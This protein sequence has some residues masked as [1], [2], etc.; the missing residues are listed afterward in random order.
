MSKKE[1]ISSVADLIGKI[2]G[3]FE[4]RKLIYRG[5]PKSYDGKDDIRSSI[6]GEYKN[7]NIFDDNN[8]PMDEEKK[9]VDRARH[10]FKPDTTN[11]EIL[12]ELR[13]YGGDTVLIDFSRDLMVALFFACNGDMEHE[14][15]IICCLEAGF[16]KLDEIDYGNRP[17]DAHIIE[18]VRTPN[19]QTRTLAQSSVFIYA[20]EGYLDTESCT[21]FYVPSNFKIQILEQL[22]NIHNIYARTIYND[23]PGFLDSEKKFKQSNTDFSR[24]KAKVD[25]NEFE[26]AILLF[27]KA[28]AS[29]YDNTEA[30]MWRALAYYRT[31]N[32]SKS[33]DDFSAVIKFSPDNSRY[34]YY[35]GWV[36]EQIEEYSNAILDFDEAIRL[37]QS[38]VQA[39]EHRANSKEAIGD[40]E[41]AVQDRE[42]MNRLKIKLSKEAHE[43]GKGKTRDG[44][45]EEA[46]KEYGKAID[47]KPDF[48]DPY[49]DRGLAKLELRQY[50][51]AIE[52]FDEYIRLKPNDPDA[53]YYRSFA[54]SEM[55]NNEGAL[56]DIDEAISIQPDNAAY[57]KA[58]AKLKYKMGN[59][60]GSVTDYSEVITQNPNDVDALKGRSE[61]HEALGQA[62]TAEADLSLAKSVQERLSKQGGLSGILQR[63]LGINRARA[64]KDLF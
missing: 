10:L 50:K 64:L 24:G 40:T 61:A 55:Q 63:P 5:M 52:D 18:P 44:E 37:D 38:F 25:N 3:R 32:F 39:Y 53:Y 17:T 21:L 46:I 49:Y 13:H 19:S 22:Q 58:R 9:I 11:I 36:H 27:D 4:S 59:Y 14:G 1:Y 15:L 23:L 7:E 51:E 30:L 26:E 20:P 45:H 35:R 31:N 62:K 8:T 42:S 48:P 60:D 57:Y 2:Q 12:T 54:K 6:Y 47:Y 33:I 16:E 41:G 29:R 43:R 56:T 34:Y 28:I